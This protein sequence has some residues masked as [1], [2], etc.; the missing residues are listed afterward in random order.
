MM[1]IKHIIQ[2]T[3][4]DDCIIKNMRKCKYIIVIKMKEDFNVLNWDSNKISEC[5]FTFILIKIN[6]DYHC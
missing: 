5:L 3:N 2:V 4:E 6:S 1:H